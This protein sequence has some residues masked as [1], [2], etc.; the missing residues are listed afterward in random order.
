MNQG[1]GKTASAVFKQGINSE[2]KT[3]FNFLFHFK[4]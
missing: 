3:R 2:E 1:T 4:G